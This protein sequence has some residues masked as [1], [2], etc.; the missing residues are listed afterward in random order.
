MKKLDGEPMFLKLFNKIL[1]LC[2]IS[3]N[4][5]FPRPSWEGAAAELDSHACRHKLLSIMAGKAGLKMVSCARV[6]EPSG[7]FTLYGFFRCC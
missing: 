5:V 2:G 3:V 6:V 4:R 7:K 1:H